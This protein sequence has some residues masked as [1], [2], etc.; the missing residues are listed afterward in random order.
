M[1]SFPP[2]AGRNSIRLIAE[3][4]DVEQSEGELVTLRERKQKPLTEQGFAPDCR[5]LTSDDASSGGGIRTPDT[6][7]MIPLL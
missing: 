6:R 3:P 5:W 7:I 1:C 4:A 2:L